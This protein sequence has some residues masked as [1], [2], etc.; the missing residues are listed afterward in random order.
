[1]SGMD[2]PREGETKEGGLLDEVGGH[3]LSA[4]WSA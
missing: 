2:G 3:M 4:L 1:M